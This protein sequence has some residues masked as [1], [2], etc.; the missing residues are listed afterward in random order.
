[1]IE[2][3]HKN[4]L[5][6]PL[7]PC[8]HDPAT[9]Y[10]RDGFC[11]TDT[12]DRGIHVVCAIVT[13]EFLDY[14]LSKGNDLMT[15]M[16]AYGFHGLKDGDSWCLCASRWLEAFEAGVAPPV[17]LISTH[18]KALEIIPLALLKQHALQ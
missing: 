4:L 13:Q 11:R 16:P 14:S 17:K 1:M 9:G 7:S 8:C 6:E 3:R 10:F 2:K 18:E 5:G 12:T 15:P